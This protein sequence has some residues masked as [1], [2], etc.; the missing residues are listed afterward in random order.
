MPP[1][2]D[3]GPRPKKMQAT[4]N[5]PNKKKLH[6]HRNQPLDVFFSPKSVAVI[7]ATENP[8]SVGR[9][10]LWNL[11]TSPFGGTV[12]PV[13]PKR[14][15]VLGVKAYASVSDIPEEVDLAVIVTP[16]PSIPG[17]IKECGENGR[18]RRDRDLGRIQGDRP[19][20]RGARA[21]PAGRSAGGQHPRD[22]AQ[23][24]G[25]DESALGHER[26]LR[27]HRR[28]AGLGRLHQPE[29]RAVHRGPRLEP[30]GDGRLQRVRLRRVDGG[31]RLGR[32]DLPPRQ[33]PEDPLASSST[34]RR[35]A[36]RGRSFR[37]RAKWR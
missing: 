35:S 33:R 34:W 30:E 24:P 6:P 12:Y 27:D 15:S 17:L 1:R 4:T 16:P 23:L 7:G 3:P 9:T 14:S 22:R 37:R 25:R 29:R 2:S 5:K 10:L 26:H 8:G 13:N 28:A 19:G 18:S 36:T 21:A 11:V 20:R 31:R 32:P